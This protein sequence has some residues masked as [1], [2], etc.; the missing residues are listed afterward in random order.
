MI[1]LLVIH[2][3]TELCKTQRAKYVFRPSRITVLDVVHLVILAV[4]KKRAVLA[5]GN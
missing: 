5:S 3:Y 4:N 1:S 2:A